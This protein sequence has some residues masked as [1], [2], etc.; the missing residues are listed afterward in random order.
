MPPCTVA[1]KL[2]NPDIKN[3]NRRNDIKIVIYYR[4]KHLLK[5]E[6]FVT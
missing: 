5:H 4:I 1:N 2:R 3:C 6:I